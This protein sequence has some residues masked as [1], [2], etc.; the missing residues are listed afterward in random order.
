MAELV[1]PDH[2]GDDFCSSAHPDDADREN[3]AQKQQACGR[4]LPVAFCGDE[5]RRSARPTVPAF[6][7]NV[8]EGE[9]GVVFRTR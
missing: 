7:A 8:S 4:N 9:E 2:V 6:L 5:V 3:K 1:H